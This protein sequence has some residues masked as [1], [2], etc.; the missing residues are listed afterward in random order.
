LKTEMTF[1]PGKK[2]GVVAADFMLIH[3]AQKLSGAESDAKLAK[4]LKFCIKLSISTVEYVKG[5]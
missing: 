4:S 1:G 2:W 5:K 3:A